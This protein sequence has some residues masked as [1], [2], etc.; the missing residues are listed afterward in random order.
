[1]IV[2]RMNAVRI[3]CRLRRNEYMKG[4][5]DEFTIRFSRPSGAKSE[6]AKIVE[7]WGDYLFYGFAGESPPNIARWFIG[8]LKAFRLAVVRY[9][10]AN[11]GEMPGKVVSNRDES[12]DF[13]S[14]HLSK[15]PPD[16]FVSASW[17]VK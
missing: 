6:F 17:N 3:A 10:Y 2:L 14:V 4:F 8:D 15:L 11:K 9:M 7:G 5:G 13:L 1:M 12:S 16:F